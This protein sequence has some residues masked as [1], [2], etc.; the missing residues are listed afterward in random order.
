VCKRFWT[1]IQQ[2]SMWKHACL[3]AWNERGK[4]AALLVPEQNVT[5]YLGF[6]PA[7][8]EPTLP[9]HRSWHWLAMALAVCSL[10]QFDLI[11]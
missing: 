7:M 8:K 1:A 9:P 4:I 2:E 5:E 3:K 6:Q 10:C 11:F